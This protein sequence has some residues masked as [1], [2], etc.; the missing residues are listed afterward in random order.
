MMCS[1]FEFCENYWPDLSALGQL[2]ERYLYS[3][4]N[5]C[6]IKIG[7]MSENIMLKMFEYE[8]IGKPSITTSLSLTRI[9]KAEGLI[10]K[11]VEDSL[12]II[13]KARNNAVHA[14]YDS[15]E[16]AKKILKIGFNLCNW[17]MVVY[18]DWKYKPNEFVLPREDQS[19]LEIGNLEEQINELQET[20]DISKTLSSEIPVEQRLAI[21]ND[22]SDKMVHLEP[23]DQ[24]LINNEKIRFEANVVPMVNYAMSQNKINIVS[25]IYLKNK[26]KEALEDVEIQFE[27]SPSFFEPFTYNVSYLPENSDV[28]INDNLKLRVNVDYLINLTEKISGTLTI[29]IVSDNKELNKEIYDVSLLAYDQWNGLSIYPELLCSFVTPNHPIVGKIISESADLLEKWTKNAAIDAYQ[30]GDK[31]RVRM[32][33]AALYGSIQKLN[34]A[35]SE[36]PASFGIGQRI[37]LSETIYQQRLGNCLDLTLLYASCLEQIG[38][39]ALLI[40]KE[41]HAFLGYWLRDTTLNEV[42][43]DDVDCQII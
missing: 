36:L 35:Y 21:G 19:V 23:E 10:P 16:D 13:R 34:I 26:T 22:A 25:D 32:Q 20:D 31:N 18:G 40:L 30:S 37:R 1:N 7:M 3:D 39:N 15:L 6:I 28:N 14:N 24:D 12:Y 8:K 9:L 41:G 4:S 11:N 42:V 29:K 43:S 38:L 17:F 33:A 2:A 27:S 5:A